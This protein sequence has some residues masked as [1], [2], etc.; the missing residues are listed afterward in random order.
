MESK[1]RE[2]RTQGE[3]ERET[4]PVPVG[5]KGNFFSFKEEIEKDTHRNEGDLGDA[6][7]EIE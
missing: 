1:E 5:Q 7:Q 3:R 6:L 2:K 4:R